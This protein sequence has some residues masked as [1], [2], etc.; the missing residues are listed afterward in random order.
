ML[1][2]VTPGLISASISLMKVVN[3]DGISQGIVPALVAAFEAHDY[4]DCVKNLHARG[5]D[6]EWYIDSLDRVSPPLI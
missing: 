3:W 5:I 2:P 1:A 6:L 4:P